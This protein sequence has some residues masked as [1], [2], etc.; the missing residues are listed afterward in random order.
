MDCIE[1]ASEYV[2]G[3]FVK[4]GLQFGF[5]GR[6]VGGRCVYRCNEESWKSRKVKQHSS[7]QIFGVGLGRGVA[8][9]AVRADTMIA[10]PRALQLDELK[11]SLALCCPLE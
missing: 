9:S 2:E 6:S 5:N 1:I 10:S 4:Q 11:C 3:V 7:D 8:Y